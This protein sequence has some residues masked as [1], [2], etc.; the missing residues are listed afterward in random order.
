MDDALRRHRRQIAQRLSLRAPQEQSLEILADFVDAISFTKEL[1]P[2]VAL[3]EIR[4][5]YPS[6]QDFEREFPSLCFAIA[7]GVGKTRLMGAFIALLFLAGLSKNFFVLA[8]NTTIYDKLVADFT[9]ETAPKYVFRGI[10]AFAQSPPHIVTGENWEHMAAQVDLF[11]RQGEVAINIFNVDK[12]NKDKGRIRTLRETIGESYFAYLASPPDLVLLMD[13]AHRYRGSAGITG[14]SSSRSTPS[15]AARKA[16][17]RLPGSSASRPT[18]RPRSS[19]TSTSS[20]KA[21]TSPI[22]SPSCRS[23]LPLPIS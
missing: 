10:A 16:T 5:L 18:R 14:T 20:R 21:G 2:A 7:T 12:I 4:K 19:S 9:R 22:S 11:G 8:P 13:E 6:A 17:R 1:D 15:S 23:G 3:A